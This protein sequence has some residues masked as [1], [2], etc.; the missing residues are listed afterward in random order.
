[1]YSLT[2]RSL[3]AV[4]ASMLL[5]APEAAG[6]TLDT[7][8]AAPEVRVVPGEHYRGNALLRFLVGDNY[9]V[10]WQRPLVVPVLDLDTFGGGLE[11]E[12]AGGNQSRTLHFNAPDG[13]TWIF[14]SVDK[15]PSKTLSPDVQGTVIDDV[16]HDHVSSL[17]PGG[18]FVAEP[19]ASAAGLLAVQPVLRVMPREQGLGQ[20]SGARGGL[21]RRGLLSQR[22][23]VA[24]LHR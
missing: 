7:T 24:A 11:V 6:Q 5:V 23:S 17:H 4:V 13:R 3:T 18:A 22:I 12:K 9:R 20:L 21:H 19:L 8:S 2:A 1:M 16:I 14:R 15:F 10:L